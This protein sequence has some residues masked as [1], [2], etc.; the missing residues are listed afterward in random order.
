MVDVTLDKSSFGSDLSEAYVHGSVLAGKLVEQLKPLVRRDV[1]LGAVAD[2]DYVLLGGH[3]NELFLFGEIDCAGVHS[4][5]HLLEIAG[6]PT[7]TQKT[8]NW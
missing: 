6:L 7:S 4:G 5:F 8:E 2:D 3:V 1:I